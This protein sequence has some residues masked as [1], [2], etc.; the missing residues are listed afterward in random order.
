MNTKNFSTAIFFNEPEI[1]YISQHNLW[2]FL[3]EKL[4]WITAR[5]PIAK[6]YLETHRGGKYVSKETLIRMKDLCQKNNIETAGGITLTTTPANHD[7]DLFTTYC[8]SNP[9]DL[10]D[11]KAIV[12]Y[13]AELFDSYVIDDF[14]FTH[15]KCEL[16]IKGKKDLSW[17]EYRTQLLKKVSEEIVIKESKA[18]NPNVQVIIKYPNWY[19]EYQQSGYNLEMSSFLFD[20]IYTGTET[21]DPLHTQQNL[22]RY[23][24]YFTMRYLEN[25]RPNGNMGGWF[26]TLDCSYNLNSVAEQAYLTLLSK[27][28]EAT[29]YSLGTLIRED[30]ISV[31][32]LG[33]AFEHVD[34]LMPMLGS[35]IGVATYKP[36]HSS[37]ENYLHGSLGMLGIPFEPTPYFPMEANTLF[38][39]A[40]AACDKHIISKLKDYLKGKHTLILTSGFVKAMAQKGL[41]ELI[42]IKVTDSKISSNH[43]GVGWYS[44]AYNHYATSP[45][46]ITFPILEFATNDTQNTIAALTNNKSYPILLQTNYHNSQVY[47]LNIPDEYGS[48]EKLPQDVLNYI[49][50]LCLK[51]FKLEVNGPAPFSVFLYDNE[52]IILYNF[53]DH[54]G[55]YSLI[56]DNNCCKLQDLDSNSF[57]TGDIVNSKNTF[58]FKINSH[59]FKVLKIVSN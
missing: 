13:T 56:I 37:G 46:P 38:L 31:P 35:P 58:N 51:D 27:A 19:D 39:T 6:I 34:R 42:D 54:V 1:N 50:K 4:N 59:R 2:D 14:F 28:K 29:I 26:D 43:F 8:Y 24:S 20:G 53:T 22:Q 52:T 3:D 18:V 49:R 33:Y 41:D 44:C 17:A 7:S 9:K 47:V 23:S 32:V 16:C 5:A 25:T 10:E 36:F 57:I 48:L 30:L 12:R 21:R 40:S 11:I 55:E 45:E 15:C